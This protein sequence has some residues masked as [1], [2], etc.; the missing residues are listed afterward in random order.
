MT[1]VREALAIKSELYSF[2]SKKFSSASA[3]DNEI[4]P[5]YV[6]VEDTAAT[7]TQDL[8]VDEKITL[9]SFAF[10]LTLKK[11][12]NAVKKC[13]KFLIMITVVSSINFVVAEPLKWYILSDNATNLDKSQHPPGED[14]AHGAVQHS[15]QDQWMA[16]QWEPM[17]AHSQSCQHCLPSKQLVQVKGEKK[18][19]KRTHYFV[20]KRMTF[21]C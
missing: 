11:N 12:C 5:N 8:N 6:K 7:L 2:G 1:S 16:S 3:F 10:K 13:F 15:L 19:Q 4:S 18:K 17:H 9:S 21:L 14:Q 20:L